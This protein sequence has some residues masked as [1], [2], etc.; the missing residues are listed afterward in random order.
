M[1]KKFMDKNRHKEYLLRGVPI[2]VWKLFKSNLA[3]N[4]QSIRMFLIEKIMEYNLDHSGTT[5]EELLDK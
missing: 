3:M 2:G 1:D 4:G 5:T